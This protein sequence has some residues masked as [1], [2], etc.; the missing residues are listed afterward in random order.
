MGALGQ[1][2]PIGGTISDAGASYLDTLG[3]P[4][5]EAGA[6]SGGS[7]VKD[8]AG[9]LT[10]AGANSYTGQHHRQRRHPAHRGQPV[11]GA[12]GAI[13]V[14]AG[15]TLTSGA[16]GLVVSAID[17][18]DQGTLAGNGNMAGPVSI[19]SGGHLAPGSACPAR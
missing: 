4:Y 9:T 10:L 5:V 11:D 3:R 12:T 8:G 16:S 1:R 13:T 6:A 14:N 17:G 19:A 2:R 7:L 18:P 15:G